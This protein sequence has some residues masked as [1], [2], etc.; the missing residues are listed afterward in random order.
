[1]ATDP[2]ITCKN[3]RKAHPLTSMKYSRNGKDMI[4][5]GCAKIESERFKQIGLLNLKI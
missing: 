5:P 3:C 1:M 2:N 4:C